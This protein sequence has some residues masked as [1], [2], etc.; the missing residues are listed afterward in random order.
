MIKKETKRNWPF[1]INGKT[2]RFIC[3]KLGFTSK[4]LAFEIGYISGRID[5][6]LAKGKLTGPAA[7]SLIFICDKYNLNIIE[8]IKEASFALTMAEF[9]RECQVSRMTVS[10]WLKKGY[11]TTL[12]NYPYKFV[13][14]YDVCRYWSR[15]YKFPVEQILPLKNI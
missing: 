13:H 5:S 2:W 4:E 14:L 7:S 9:A 10:R 15:K 8:L 12:T 1:E 11:F 3:A 6:V